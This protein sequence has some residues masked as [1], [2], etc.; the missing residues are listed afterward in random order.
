MRLALAQWS[1]RAG[2]AV[3]RGLMLDLAVEFGAEDEGVS[4]QIHPRQQRDDGAER[5]VG[6]VVIG[7]ASDVDAER[8]GQ[9][10]QRDRG[11]Q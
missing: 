7:E 2:G 10:S 11:E 4:G 1:R 3:L 8:P 9:S 5:A 6:R